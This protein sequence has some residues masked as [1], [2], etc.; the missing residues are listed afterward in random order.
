MAL[1]LARR[2]RSVVGMD[3]DTAA[4]AEARRQAEAAGMTNLTLLE[5]DA[6]EVEYAPL[7]PDMIVAHLFASDAMIARAGRA[8]R[9]GQC[10]C[11][12][13]IHVDQWR[14]TGR[15]SRFAYDEQRME[16]TLRASGL[17]PEV[18][19]VERSERRFASASEAL[20]AAAPLADRWKT[21]GRWDGYRAFVERGGRS[22]T[23]SLLV[24]KA[25]RR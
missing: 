18:V 1:W 23:Q 24:V 17:I 9:P 5:M 6:D 19:E 7:E 3:R 13:A 20:E 16:G 8:L 11:L 21:D 12:V 4:L 14:E 10:L 22:L 25:R 2:A 15:A